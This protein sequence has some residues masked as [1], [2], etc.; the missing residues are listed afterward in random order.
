[1]F[2]EGQGAEGAV[3]GAEAQWEAELL[4]AAMLD[5]SLGASVL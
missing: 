4:S 2:G 1:M 3:G 5:P